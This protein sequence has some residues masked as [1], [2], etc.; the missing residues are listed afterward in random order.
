MRRIMIGNF[1]WA[2]LALVAMLAVRAAVSGPQSKAKATK[3]AVATSIGY[4]NA[5]AIS[6]EEL[7]IYL[8]FLASDQ[9]EG[10]N[11]PSRG[12][13]TAALYIASH[14]A[15]WG[16]R[17]GGSTTNTN[18]PLQRYFMPIEL[19]SRQ[20]LTA[21]SKASITAPPGGRGAGGQGGGGGARDAAAPQ[22]MELEYGK[23]WNV[24]GGGRG[25]PPIAPLDA[26]G[27][28]VFAGNGYVINKT[29]T[30]RTTVWTFTARSS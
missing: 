28:L 3:I 27:N 26:T 15:E 9:M 18:G 16:L 19:A 21:E 20:V 12:Y 1:A 10:R 22:K 4:G 29:N 13:D 24:N 6:E 17:P 25:G 5:D 23:G 14:L 7:K 11:L 8:Y 2:G 30:N